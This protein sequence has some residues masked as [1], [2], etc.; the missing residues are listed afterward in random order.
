MHTY[1]SH[2]KY[3]NIRA[4]MMSKKKTIKHFIINN[5]LTKVGDFIN[6]A[7]SPLIPRSCRPWPQRV[8]SFSCGERKGIP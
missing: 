3:I 1:Y 4:L 6:L 5:I 8:I 7:P 2:F